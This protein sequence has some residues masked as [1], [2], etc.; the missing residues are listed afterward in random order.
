MCKMQLIYPRANAKI[1]L[2][3]HELGL[4]SGAGEVAVPLCAAILFH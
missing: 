4:N 3:L 2:K 1:S